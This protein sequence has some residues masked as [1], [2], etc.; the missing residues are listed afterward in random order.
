MLYMAEAALSELCGL[1]EERAGP[2]DREEEMG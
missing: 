1:F 2:G